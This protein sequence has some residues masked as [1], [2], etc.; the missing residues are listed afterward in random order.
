VDKYIETIMGA[1]AAIREQHSK[2]AAESRH[3]FK[4]LEKRVHDLEV[5]VTQL[6]RLKLV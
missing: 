6:K 3:D 5:K 2:L 4:K 1:I